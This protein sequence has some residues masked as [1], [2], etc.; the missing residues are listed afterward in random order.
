M[1]GDRHR[2]LLRNVLDENIGDDDNIPIKRT[3]R[4]LKRIYREE[5]LSS[6]SSQ[7]KTDQERRCIQLVP[8]RE[9]VVCRGEGYEKPL[10][11]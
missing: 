4:F 9:R 10:T 5:S 2:L 7:G 1:E 3:V 8:A 11:S 6:H